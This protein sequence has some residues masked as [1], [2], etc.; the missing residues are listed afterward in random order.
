VKVRTESAPSVAPA[1]AVAAPTPS[2]PVV[3]TAAAAP[4]P[5]AMRGVSK[6]FD[7]RPANAD[8]NLDVRPGEIHALL[9][10]NG[11]GKTTLMRI[12]SGSLRPDAGRIAVGG[13]PV[14]FQS[15]ADALRHG[16][17]MVHQHSVLVPTLTVAENVVLGHEPPWRL[18]MRRRE[19]L[20]DVS[21]R[22]EQCGLEVD[23]G[24]LVGSLSVDV[25][26]R[27]E[28]LRLLFRDVATLILDEPT[29]ILAR[30]H[31]ERLFE[32]LRD[33]RAQGRAIVVVT[34]KLDEV[35]ELAD[36]ATVLRR[37]RVVD[38]V[39][40]AAFD[41][42]ALT[43]ALVGRALA[44]IAPPAPR[45]PPRR[46]GAS[47]AVDDV[48]VR[49]DRSEDAVAGLSLEIGAGEILGLA[50]VEGNGQVELVEALSGVRPLSAGRVRV[51]D[52]T[53]S[54]VTPAALDRLGVAVVSADRSRWDVFPELSAGENLLLSR[55]AEG[56][57]ELTR[58]GFVRRRRMREAARARLEEFDVR[59]CEP[60]QPVGTLS[61]GNQQRVVLAR[62]LSRK[63][64]AV[65]AAYPTR[66]LD[67]AATRFVHTT[68]LQLRD[69]GSAVLL[70][71]ADLDELLALSDRA[72]VLYR[73]RL[74]Y[75]SETQAADRSAMAAAM[76]GLAG[77]D[78]G[79]A[80]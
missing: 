4:D 5:V 6:S 16:I 40:R 7:A 24:R 38:V 19:L 57:R 42:Q 9:G 20:R 14:E 56:D 2:P 75:L 29:A 15:P 31:V 71:S 41:E 30:P 62:E 39:E 79:R 65:I 61:G 18:R 28:I 36:R 33:L 51:G 25:A 64:V 27:V 37:G 77:H 66:G 69:S 67:L 22:A 32:T 80:G 1:T 63:P 60:D 49:G 44:P 76:V 21:A 48:N 47:Y 10:E 26:Q 34:H 72:G 55:I 35:L 3:A 70:V 74:S 52:H 54:R 13:E 45:R 46:D 11:A 23:P 59:P 78:G 58:W 8:V 17:G 53:L 73:G 50:G 12:L 68:L 43:E